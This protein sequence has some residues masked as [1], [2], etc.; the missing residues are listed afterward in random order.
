[1]DGN[2]QFVDVL[3]LVGNVAPV[4][5][6]FLA[7]GLVNSH[8]RP[9]LITSRADF[10]A[11]TGVLVPVALWPIPAFVASGSWW[12]M[13]LGCAAIAFLFLWLLPKSRSGFVV[14]NI[15]EAQC[16]GMLRQALQA[17]GYSGRWDGASWQADSGR[18]AIHLRGFAL[19]RNVS[20]HVEAADRVAADDV[21]LIGEELQKRL[22]SVAQLPSPMGAG[23][24]LIGLAMMI[25]PMWMVGRHIDDIVDAMSHLFG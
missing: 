6:Y 24:V 20:I 21:P 23:L 16:A 11:L 17:L 13:V 7:L 2:Y 1:M 8:A 12:P 19:L 5:V 14:Y 3:L 10:V 18:L 22:Q 9:Y 4:A 15:S 25:L